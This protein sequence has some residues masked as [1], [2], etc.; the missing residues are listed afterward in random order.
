V[1]FAALTGTP[2]AGLLIARDGGGYTYAILFSGISMVLAA[3]LIVVSRVA[4]VGV[5]INRVT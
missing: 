1:S 5:K 4:Q 2:I 3:V